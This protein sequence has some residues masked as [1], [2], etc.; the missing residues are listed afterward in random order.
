LDYSNVGHS[1]VVVRD[2][3]SIGGMGLTIAMSDGMNVGRQASA[4]A[5]YIAVSVLLH[6]MVLLLWPVPREG[7]EVSAPVRVMTATIANLAISPLPVLSEQATKSESKKPEI[8]NSRRE[9]EARQSVLTAPAEVN[10]PVTIQ[11]PT[12]TS[13]VQPAPP[14]IVPVTPAQ[15]VRP[16]ESP[17]AT[18]PPNGVASAQ[19]DSVD[20]GS[21]DQYRLALISAARRY[22]RYPAQAMERGWQ[23]KVEVRLVIAADGRI[24]SASVRTS[25]GY[26]ILDQQ[27]L[28][29]ITKGKTLAQIPGALRGRDFVVDVPVIFDLQP[30]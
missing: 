16:V 7:G 9:V 11:A 6:V 14:P 12:S 29:M 24:K 8:S 28:D 17:P 15:Q 4:M 5:G 3:G 22:K 23:G 21:L 18:S 25:S 20:A 2:S 19:S 27:A 26:G 10:S 1:F 13:V 30:S